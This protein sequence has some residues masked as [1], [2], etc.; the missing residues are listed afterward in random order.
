MI[1]EKILLPRNLV[2]QMFHQAQ[3]LPDSEVCGLISA[4]GGAVMRCYPVAN[5]SGDPTHLFD[6]DTQGQVRAMREI[7][8]RG[9]SL[10]AIYHSHPHAPPEPSARDLELSTYPEAYHLI[11]SLNT[12]GVLEMRAWK[13]I[14]GG[15]DEVPVKIIP[16]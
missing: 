11:I 3:A 9:E 8:E 2:Q 15:M 6:M 13:P 7:R 10:F 5:V 1:P 4:V 16:D 14:A 12:K